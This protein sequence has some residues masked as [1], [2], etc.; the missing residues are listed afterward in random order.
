MKGSRTFILWLVVIAAIGV[1]F[2]YM[3]KNKISNQPNAETKEYIEIVNAQ[4][5]IETPDEVGVELNTN[6]I[7]VDK[8]FDDEKTVQ[9]LIPPA[10]ILR[11]EVKKNPH[12]APIS[13]MEFSVNLAERVNLALT[14]DRTIREKIFAELKDC[15]E[16]AESSNNSIKALCLAKAKFMSEKDDQFKNS[17]EVL[18]GK[19]TPEVV[20]IAKHL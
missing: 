3:D 14:K 8:G 16:S 12:Q 1:R 20:G 13:I 11:Q 18:L 15:V 5:H 7:P 17:Y 6:S 10:S 9:K 2:L 4:T 19:A